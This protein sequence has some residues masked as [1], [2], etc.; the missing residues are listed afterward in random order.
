[1]PHDTVS[2]ERSKHFPENSKGL[3]AHPTARRIVSNDPSP[4]FSLKA[5]GFHERN[6]K[7]NVSTTVKAKVS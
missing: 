6:H 5:D 2:T 4:N 7:A 1:M 3:S